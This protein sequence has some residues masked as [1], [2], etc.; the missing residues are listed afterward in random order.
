MSYS[1]KL[2]VHLYKRLE[3]HAEGFDTPVNVIEKILNHYEGIDEPLESLSPAKLKVARKR[4]NTKYIFN[5]HTYGKGRL[6]LAVVKDYVAKH[7]ESSFEK[8]LEVFPKELQGTSG[9]FSELDDAKEVY[10]RT[11]HKRHFLNNDE[12]IELSDCVIAVSTEWGAGNI[13]N[14]INTAKNQGFEILRDNSSS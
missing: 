12:T 10:V 9:V 14:L 1:I 13:E 5:S 8:L 7:P 6:V 3:K 4:D 11:S 2:P